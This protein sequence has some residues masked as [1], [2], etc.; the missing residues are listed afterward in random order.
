[1]KKIEDIHKLLKEKE[2]TKKVRIYFSTKT[3]G[4]NFDPYERNY[5]ITALNPQTIRAVV[6]MLSPEALVWKQYGLSEMGAVE[7]L[8]DL[9]YKSWFEN[10]LK[11]EIDSDIYSVFKDGTGTRAIMQERPNDVLRVVLQKR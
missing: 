7:I 4:D 2:Y 1:M 5:T 6:R 9:K 11:V 3:A 8:T 10:A